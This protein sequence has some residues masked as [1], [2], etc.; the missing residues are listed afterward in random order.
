MKDNQAKKNHMKIILIK[1][2][3]LEVLLFREMA[4]FL[5]GSL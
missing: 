4:Y 2:L 1:K 3:N 5:I